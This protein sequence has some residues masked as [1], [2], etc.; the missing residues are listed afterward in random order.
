MKIEALLSDFDASLRRLEE[1]L[2]RE[3][4]DDL[5]RAGC[6]QYFEFTFE[7]AWKSIQAVAAFHGVEP[8]RSPRA[9]FKT[10][11]SQTWITEQEPWLA[12][13]EARNRMSHVYNPSE[14]LAVFAQLPAF[15]AP[16][17]QL[18]QRLTEASSVP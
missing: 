15:T 9:A 3:P 1:A 13:L 18:H 16:L 10:A 8:V 14:A 4:G 2:G 11:F 5:F 7:L 12:M 17:R 6:I